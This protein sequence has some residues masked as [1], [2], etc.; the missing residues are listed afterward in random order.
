LTFDGDLAREH[1]RER[2]SAG[3]RVSKGVLHNLLITH[4]K[5]DREQVKIIEEA[6][7]IP[8]EELDRWMEP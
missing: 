7:K 5:Y 6:F 2:E 1:I 4:Q 8:Q 3:H